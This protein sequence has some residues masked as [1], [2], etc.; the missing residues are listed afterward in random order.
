VTG[1]SEADERVIADE[2]VL[3]DLKREERRGDED[4]HPRE[5]PRAPYRLR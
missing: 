1:I 4:Q 3:V 2:V 5:D